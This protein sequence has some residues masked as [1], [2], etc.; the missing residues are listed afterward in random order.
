MPSA[1]KPGTAAS[2]CAAASA[3]SSIGDAATS[4]TYAIA[5]AAKACRATVAAAAVALV[6]S[7][8]WVTAVEARCPVA[9]DLTFIPAQPVASEAVTIRLRVY[10]SVFLNFQ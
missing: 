6:L 3:L 10:L 4:M 7:S 8:L 2:A 9:Q 1:L 5:A